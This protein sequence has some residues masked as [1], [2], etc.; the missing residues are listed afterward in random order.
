MQNKK[1]LIVE[2]DED[3][4]FGYTQILSKTGA[5][6]SAVTTLE[7]AKNAMASR[8]FDG[9]LLDLNLPDG[10]S[11]EW[12]PEL[13]RGNENMAV[14][15]LTAVS[16]VATAVKAMK[17][18]ADNYLTKPVN[19]EELK[20]S[21]EKCLELG[22]LK[23]KQ[24]A[25]QRISKRDELFLGKSPA[26]Q[27]AARH[28]NMAADSDTIVFLQGE[29]GTGKG[30]FARWIHD[31][32]SRSQAP[33][34]ELNCSMLRGE[35]LR[36]ELFGHVKGAFTSAIK[37]RVG[38]IEAADGGTLFLDEIGDMDLEL[39]S[40]LLK[41]IEE[42]TFRRLG[43]N[44]IRTS[45]FRLICATHRD[46]DKWSVEG[47]FRQDLFFRINVFPIHLP[48]LGQ[49]KE[50]IP[51][52]ADYLLVSLGYQHGPLSAE[53]AELLVNRNWPGNVRELRN[54][55]ERAMLFAQDQA[56]SPAHFPVHGS[57]EN[58]PPMP[59]IT[60]KVRPLVEI[61]LEYMQA[62]LDYFKGDKRKASQ[63]LGISLSSLYRKLPQLQNPE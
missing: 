6:I 46:L 16:D 19:M 56:L 50:D 34:V 52:M 28:G 27:E 21:L 24:A 53:I 4:A 36:S 14:I 44:R 54:I 37:D 18:G 47:R 42:R 1:I 32:S 11:M 7:Q 5:E 12:L 35:M 17:A 62:A 45:S 59:A 2:D 48:P 33:F 8:V 25:Q 20:I 55:L 29:T 58:R 31:R 57:R 60:E 63:A 61:E 15:I 22:E 41:A 10:N 9:V 38:L 49:R 30:V 26:I 40:Q 39:Q 23:K 13:K 51:A 3:A 43:E